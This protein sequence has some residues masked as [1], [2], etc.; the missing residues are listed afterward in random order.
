MLRNNK[1]LFLAHLYPNTKSSTDGKFE[2]RNIPC[3]DFTL[4]PFYKG[5]N[6][7]F[8]VSPKSLPFTVDQGR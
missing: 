4:V 8:D 5:A 7:V 1:P 3:G 6:T 2:F